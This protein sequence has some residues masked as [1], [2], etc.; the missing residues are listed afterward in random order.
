MTP[1]HGKQMRNPWF[2]K[3][4]SSPGFLLYLQ[5]LRA[6]LMDMCIQGY[7]SPG[8]VK[9]D[10]ADN[11]LELAPKKV[12][13]V[14]GTKVQPYNYF[15]NKQHLQKY[16]AEELWTCGTVVQQPLAE[17]P[18][19][20]QLESWIQLLHMLQMEGH[21]RCHAFQLLIRERDAGKAPKELGYRIEW[22]IRDGVCTLVAK[23]LPASS[24]LKPT[25]GPTKHGLK[26]SPGIEGASPLDRREV[27]PCF[28]DLAGE[29]PGYVL[30]HNT[31]VLHMRTKLFPPRLEILLSPLL[32]DIPLLVARGFVVLLLQHW[33]SLV[34]LPGD[35]RTYHSDTKKLFFTDEN[36]RKS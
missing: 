19:A 33:V 25:S 29:V 31:T 35:E 15:Y 4:L 34:A 36:G 8:V 7:F 20:L 22:T 24:S 26:P 2:S 28:G 27:P 3:S 14:S 32:H 12:I 9:A 6:S 10:P 21:M 11:D 18:E 16:S 5:S 23:H 13:Y 30:Q 17:C 1:R